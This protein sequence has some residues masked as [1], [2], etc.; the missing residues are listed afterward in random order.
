LAAND[1]RPV[2]AV[3]ASGDADAFF[4]CESAGFGVSVFAICGVLLAAGGA[5]VGADDAVLGVCAALFGCC[6][7]IAAALA[8]AGFAGLELLAGCDFADCSA[9]GFRLLATD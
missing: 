7:V 6:L 4:D 3:R 1:W 8:A 5:V 2:L 9:A